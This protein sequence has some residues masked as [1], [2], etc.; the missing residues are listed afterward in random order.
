MTIIFCLSNLFIPQTLTLIKNS[1]SKVL[2][3]TDQEGINRFFS[4]LILP[5]VELFYRKRIK[6]RRNLKSV[7]GLFSKRKQILEWL[8]D[9]NPEQV[10]FFHNTFGNIE[11][12]IIKNLSKKTNLFHAPVFNELPFQVTYS[13]NSIIG[14]AKNYIMH[15][16]ITVPLWN[17]E[18]YIFKLPEK[19]Y[20]RYRINRLNINIDEDF[21]RSVLTDKFSF[22]SNKIVL[23]TGTVV[24]MNQVEKVEYVAKTN[25]LIEKIGID[26]II[27]KPHPRF[28]KQYG[29]EK[30]IV[31][32]PYYIPAN[33]L[34]TVFD[35]FVGY[36][37]GVLTEV[38]DCGLL[39]ISTIDLFKP[40]NEVKK[41][42][43]KNYLL[44][45]RV[46]P[47]S[48]IKFPTSINELVGF[49]K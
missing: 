34:Y 42:N 28:L 46:N 1:N 45:N 12:W 41:N 4:E 32:I 20:S 17:G 14:I 38:S 31:Q 15:G 19:F 24:E 30:E 36:S 10:I 49:L 21:I 48:V 35:T 9:K 33:V 37:S 8:I 7:K 25:M 23:L 29:L 18:K 2:V 16:V 44:K 26:R 6:I 22:D 40:V 13:N 5:N 43:Y 47:Y 27:A 39:S 3:Y 11:N